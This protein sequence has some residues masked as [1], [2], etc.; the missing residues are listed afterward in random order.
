[1]ILGIAETTYLMVVDYGK[2][3]LLRI[4]NAAMNRDF[5]FA[6]SEHNLTVVGWDGA[7]VKPFTTGY[8]MIAPG[9]TMDILVTANQS[10]STQYYMLISPYYDGALYDFDQ[11]IA[12]AIWQYNGNYTFPSTPSYPANLPHYDDV[13]ATR[14]FTERLRSLASQEYP[15]DVPLEVDS[16]IFVTL[17]MN[18]NPCVNDSCTGPDGNRLLASMNNMSFINPDVDI[19][20]AYYRLSLIFLYF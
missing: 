19:L 11:S 20:Q 13:S 1:M 9:Q 8:I 15:I 12:T 14:T 10:P 6:I 17:S 4:V 7:Y 16:R 18:M 5:F 3:Y 2:T